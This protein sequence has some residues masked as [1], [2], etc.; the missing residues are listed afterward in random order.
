MKKKQR[1][2]PPKLCKRELW[3]LYTALLVIKIYLPMKFGVD[4]SYFLCYAPYKIMMDKDEAAA[5]CSPVGEH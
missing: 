2:I 3:F 5:I 1:A 4:I